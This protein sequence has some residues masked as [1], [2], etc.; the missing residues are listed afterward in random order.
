MKAKKV[1]QSFFELDK[2]DRKMYMLQV[3]AMR[4]F[5]IAL[6]KLFFGLLYMSVW[7]FINGIFYAILAISKYRSVRDYTKVKKVKDKRAKERITYSNYLYN[8]WLLVLLGIAYFIINLIIFKTG[9]TN[10]DLDGYLVYLTALL[11]LSSLVTAVIS[12]KKYRTKNDPIVAAACQGNIA[13]ALTSVV[14]TQVT[15][16]DEFGP[17]IDKIVKIDGITGMFVGIIIIGLGLRMVIKITVGG[18]NNAYINC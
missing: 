14:L 5:G 6:L 1:V 18:K 4:T 10:N 3:T 2:K 11:S 12:L 9:K 8:G 15:L 7:F 16:L 17:K 13:K